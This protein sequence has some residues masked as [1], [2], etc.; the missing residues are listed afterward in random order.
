MLSCQ[1]ILGIK[2]CMLYC[3]L[4]FGG[5]KCEDYIRGFASSVRFVNMQRTANHP[6]VSWNH[7]PLLIGG[8]DCG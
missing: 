3:L 8:L 1:L 5:P 7:Y 4:T 6:Q 2:R